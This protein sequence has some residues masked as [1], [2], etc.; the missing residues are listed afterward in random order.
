MLVKYWI[1][2]FSSLYLIIGPLDI[3]M[4]MHRHF[5]MSFWLLSRL[6]YL[7]V[8]S[9]ICV[10]VPFY[11]GAETKCPPPK[12][13]N[14]RVPSFKGAKVLGLSQCRWDS[15]QSWKKAVLSPKRLQGGREQTHVNIET[16]CVAKCHTF[17][18]SA[19]VTDDVNRRSGDSHMN[20]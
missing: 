17:R 15:W 1:T 2:F 18:W 5:A 13:K 11:F 16:W 20:S 6:L 8:R 9:C 4:V 10:E 19:M 14:F 3:H 7:L 12:K